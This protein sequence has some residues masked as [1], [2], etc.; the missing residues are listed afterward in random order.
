MDEG[1]DTGRIL[2][3]ALAPIYPHDT[4][5]VVEDRATELGVRLL[6]ELLQSLSRGDVPSVPQPAGGSTRRQPTLQIR[7][8]LAMRLSVRRL[9]RGLSTRAMMKTMVGTAA[10]YLW[11]PLRDAF[12]TLR[13]A[14]PIR[15]FTY[16]RVT[17]LCRDFVTVSPKVFQRQMAYV[18]RYHD[19]V[20][21]EE[22]LTMIASGARLRRPV[23]TVTFDDGYRTVLEQAFPTMRDQHWTGCCFI[24]TDLVGT[25]RR[26]A[27]DDDNPVRKYLDVMSW[28]EIAGLQRRAWSIGAHT[29][30]HPPLSTC[31]GPAL[32]RELTRP[33]QALHER[34]GLTSIAMAYPFGEPEDI[35]PAATT[36]VR[37][38]GYAACFSNHG[39]E[40][41]P[42][43]DPFT[44]R[45]ID[46][47]G[48]HETSVW[49]RMAHGVDLGHWGR[50]W[51]RTDPAGRT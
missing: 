18:R 46:L 44:L 50:S 32:E 29:A 5:A 8:A 40:N 27:H 37:E 17:N 30:S 41:F 21:L 25:D 3:E 11:R 51:K 43:C 15:V 35:T 33:L 16:H 36:L 45:R 48:D 2:A 12:R 38:R 24:T 49:K 6:R 7:A 13:R 39:G 34:L 47:G 23:A 31:D 19:I 4:L 22:A 10:L 14:H 20:T 28:E 9:K 1:V 26:F 42:A